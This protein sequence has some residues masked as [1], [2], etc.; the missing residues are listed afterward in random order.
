VSLAYVLGFFT[1]LVV[2]GWHP[3]PPHKAGA[4]PSNPPAAQ[5]QFH[6]AEGL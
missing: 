6:D 1:L 2:M 5:T 4:A 3:N